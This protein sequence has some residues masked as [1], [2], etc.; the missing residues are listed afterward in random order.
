[1]L[2][3]TGFSAEDL[4]ADTILK[5]LGGD[6]IRYR[7]EKGELFQLLRT[8]MQRDFID[9]RRK[10]SHQ[11][12]V[13]IDLTAQEAEKDARLRDRA[14]QETLK[15]ATLLRDVR[16]LVEGDAK[17]TEYVDAVELGCVKPAEIADVCQA[18][19][20]DIYERR[21]KLKKALNSFHR[22]APV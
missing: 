20:K 11:R 1:M 16:R 13:H 22:S 21:R 14:G 17:L 9:L 10:R 19:V 3:G 18:D 4:V 12:N 7:A 15:A 2:A 8:A 6:E 5:A